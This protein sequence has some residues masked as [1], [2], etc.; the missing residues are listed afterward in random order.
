MMGNPAEVHKRRSSLVRFIQTWVLLLVAG[1]VAALTIVDLLHS[2]YNF[3]KNA[4]RIRNEYIAAQKEEIR[5]EV[6]KVVDLISQTREQAEQVSREMVRSRVYEAH[7]IA[8][9]IYLGHRETAGRDE[10]QKMIID[11][12]RPIR[13][14]NGSGYFFATRFDGVEMLFADRPETEG[15]NLLNIQDPNGKYVIKDM[16]RI[17][18]QSDEGYYEYDWT[19]PG[20]AG[21]DHKKIA[22]VKKFEPYDWFIGT[23]LYKEDIKE[24]IKEKL[25]ID[26]SNIRFGKEGYIFINQMDGVA[27]VSNGKR[28]AGDRKLW[29][30]FN[31]YGQQLRGI[32]D[33]EY[34]AAKQPDGDFIYYS[35]VK[36]SSLDSISPKT[37][38]IYGI[39]D[40]QWLVGAG[41]YLD[42]V[43]T[44]I[45][46]M[47][48]ELKREFRTKIYSVLVVGLGFG[49]LFILLFKRFS[50]RMQSDIDLLV[51]FFKKAAGNDELIDQSR[52]Q[53]EELNEL[54]IHTNEM[55]DKRRAAEEKYYC[56][57][58]ESV[59]TI[60]V[61][62]REAC[63]IDSNQAGLDLLGYSREE[64]LTRS[65]Q[66]VAVN[67]ELITTL[68]K[69][70][71]D[72]EKILGSEQQLVRKDGTII[73]VLNSSLPLIGS[74]GSVSGI[75]S[76]LVDITARKILE[77]KLQ[78]ASKMEAV[79][80]M[81][82]GV[83]H[84]L[85]NILAGI[86]GYPELLI[87]S[88]PEN[89]PLRK[90]LLDIKES[91]QKAAA[92]VADLLT[93]AKGIANNREICD[94]NELVE[95]YLQSPECKKLA[96][97]HP[98]VRHK[99]RLEASP[100]YFLC[101]T[102]HFN[103]SLMNLVVNAT[104]AIEG[105][106]EVTVRTENK[107]LKGQDAVTCG[108]KNG[109]Y[110]LLT[111]TD[112]GPGILKEDLEH[113]FEP[114]YSK[115]KM[116]RSGTGLGLTV[117]W[118]AVYD[119]GGHILVDSS[120]QGTS[121]RL[122]FPASDAKEPVRTEPAVGVIQ[123]LVGNGER[124]LVVD[125]EPHLREIASQMLGVLG[126]RVD[127]VGSGEAALVFLQHG[128]V[129]LVV[130]DMIM[131]PM[132][133]LQTYRK[134]IE[135]HPQQKAVVAS[136]YADSED[137]Q[138]TLRLGATGLIKKPYSLE[139]LG[140]AVKNALHG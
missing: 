3:R 57:F 17:V 91:G 48:V 56:I 137:M 50:N 133:G 86:V 81:A 22:F 120:E 66:S 130:L 68:C 53:F 70:L 114:F 20:A 32:F 79:G 38:F 111:V 64:L 23:G 84:D 132:N 97:L 16:I 26:I 11:A 78:R 75:Q 2:Y 4:E 112:T 69:R 21:N 62:D 134:I 139:Q 13:Y 119:H 102:T 44:E 1:I 43:E 72:G 25:L 116:Q 113:I 52:I 30:V 136:G 49:V 89:S 124:I 103:K 46:L 107:H 47:Q 74:G 31:E 51:S 58:N 5:K 80:L 100:P 8:T 36:L 42:D 121:F 39:P 35:W 117:V 104:E 15:T 73:T 77:S 40:L 28:L 88:L 54:A 18:Q 129:D 108:V 55:I 82:G 140:K 126:Y 92:I 94:I 7:A 128:S 10:L 93:V 85:N 109:D 95:S 127:A 96:S 27:L 61:F 14:A 59:A 12:L 76:T 24:Q 83:A 138:A 118:N 99:Q 110:I 19:K 9:N 90:P 37:S 67:P 125:D 122:Y 60:Y 33:Q 123:D 105:R 87:M 29:E 135:I 131:E 63:F 41:V 6:K 98:D 101:S 45:T 71:V 106:G 65:L 115:K 34:K